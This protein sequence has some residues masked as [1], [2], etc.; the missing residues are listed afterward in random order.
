MNL[1]QRGLDFIKQF[2][3]LLLNAYLCPAGVP[4]IGYGT[5][6]IDGERV[7][8]GMTITLEQ[9]EQ[10]L[11]DD[12]IGA[13]HVVDRLIRDEKVQ[14][15]QNQFDALVSFVYNVGETGFGQSTLRRMLVAKSPILADYFLRWNKI[16][17]PRT[18]KLVVSQ[19]LTNRRM[20]EY[21]LFVTP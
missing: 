14:L 2:E 5:T 21:G 20:A 4:T 9:A 19:G 15:T 17:D 1:S 7:Q 11:A 8:L 13:E 16:T 18:G 3:G 10:Y 6:M 12:C